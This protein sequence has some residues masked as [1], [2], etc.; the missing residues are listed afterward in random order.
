MSTSLDKYTQTG[1]LIG[2]R[3]DSLNTLLS[4]LTTK[5]ADIDTR[6]TKYEENLRQQ[7]GNLD[8]LLTKLS[9][10]ASSLSSLS[11]LTSS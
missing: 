7:Y 1:G 11:S 10:S 6:L 3:S 4:S 8:T 2:I 9:N 5:S